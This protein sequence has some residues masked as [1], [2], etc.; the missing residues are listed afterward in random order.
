MNKA[1]ALKTQVQ[2]TGS[3]SSKTLLSSVQPRNEPESTRKLSNAEKRLILLASKSGGKKFPPWT[4]TPD[5]NDFA[6]RSRPKDQT[7]PSLDGLFLDSADQSLCQAQKESFQGWL[8]STSAIPPP[9]WFGENRPSP[10]MK[11]YLP[12]DLVQDAA[13]DCSVVASICV[14]QSRVERGFPTVSTSPDD[15]AHVNQK[16]ASLQNYVSI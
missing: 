1:Q 3:L 2:K 10:T 6:L 9:T 5:D 7:G 12:T 11:A 14:E 13:P 15:A 4:R 8:R 16:I